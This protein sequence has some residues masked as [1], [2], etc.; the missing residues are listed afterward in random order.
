MRR[1][2]CSGF[3][4]ID[5][6]KCTLP[7]RTCLTTRLAYVFRKDK[8]TSY[9][10]KTFTDVGSNDPNRMM[11]A[12]HTLLAHRRVGLD[13]MDQ[14]DGGEGSGKSY[15]SCGAMPEL[16]RLNRARCSCSLFRSLDDIC[17]FIE[18]TDEERMD[19]CTVLLRDLP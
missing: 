12:L 14:S 15:S 6:A 3:R 17:G 18:I 2:S 16:S 1:P 4:W 11:Y 7:R 13:L 10:A 8:A 9:F 5:E 19:Y